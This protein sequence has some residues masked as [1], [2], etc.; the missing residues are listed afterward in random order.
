VSD[1]MPPLEGRTAVVT[2]A[3]RGIGFEIAGALVENGAKVVI[4]DVH[5]HLATEAAEKLGDPN[6][7]LG[8][9]CDVRVRIQIERL[10]DAAT[11]LCGH[12]LDIMVN[13]AGITRNATMRRMTEEEFDA[14]IEANLKGVWLGTQAAAARMREAGGGSIIN[15]SSLSGKAGM[16]GQ[17]NYSAAKAGVVGLTKAAAKRLYTSAS[18][19]TQCSR[20]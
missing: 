17:T 12:P 10:L 16:A 8:E 15:I 2:G 5:G 4:G 11:T 7:V 13:N 18:E 3:A 14:V 1:S 6:V 19:S 20:A 9:A